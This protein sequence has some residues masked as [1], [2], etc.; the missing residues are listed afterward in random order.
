MVGNRRVVITGVGVVSPIGIGKHDFW[1]ALDARESGVQELPWLADSDSPVRFGSEIRDFDGKAF[2][3][4]RKALKVMC[5]EIQTGYAASSLAC[6]DAQLADQSVDPDRFGVVYGCEMLYCELDDLFRVFQR[7]SA[8]QHFD[9]SLWG[10]FAMKEL[11]PLWMLKYLPNMAACHIGI[12]HDAR[13]P[14][15]TITQGEASSLLA[16]IEAVTV[17]E[18]GWADCMIAGG[19]GNRLSITALTYRG[20]ADISRRN[21]DPSAACRPFDADR[22]GMVNGEGTAAFVLE[23]QQHAE[24]RGARILA[25]VAGYSSTF[26]L[27]GKHGPTSKAIAQSIRQAMAS[28]QVAPDEIGHVNARGASTSDDDAAEAQAIRD[29]LGDVP[30]TAP[31]SFFGN[32]GAGG[33]AVEMVA[34]LLAFEKQQIPVTLN[35]QRPD[36][37][38][39]V[40]VVAEQ[41]LPNPGPYALQ[42]SQSGTGQAAA[43]LI[44]QGA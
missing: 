11:Y 19:I 4:P 16:I 8:E 24:S 9:F 15:N 2:V 6:A 30:V 14:N 13:G 38:C 25:H 23:T 12:S 31:S 28:A 5:R 37:R 44:G 22:D 27:A 26:G 39:P 35:Y 18:R 41:S 42:L 1:S 10:Q 36:P 7:C 29:C 33:G 21:D 43:L 20:H 32:L 17:I 3:T 40:R 34:S